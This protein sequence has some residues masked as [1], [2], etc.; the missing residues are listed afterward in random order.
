MADIELKCTCP[1][2]NGSLHWPCPSHP[3]EAASSVAGSPLRALDAFEQY[4]IAQTKIP[5]MPGLAARP[6]YVA[7]FKAGCLAVEAERA[8]QAA[9]AALADDPDDDPVFT[10]WREDSGVDVGDKWVAWSAWCGA[11]LTRTVT[12]SPVPADAP[13]EPEMRAEFHRQH[14]GRDLKQH[15]LRGTYLNGNIAALWNQHKRTVNWMMRRFSAP[16]PDIGIPTSK[17]M[18]AAA[19][20]AV[21]G[22]DSDPLY[23]KAVTVVRVGQRASISMVQRVL[24]IGYNRAAR[25]LEAMEKNG[26]ISHADS[27]GRRTVLPAPA[28]QPAAQAREAA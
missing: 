16:V 11:M 26:V 24:I 12:K 15:G 22:D 17:A 9:P 1:S 5:G 3:P 7:G 25:L 6:C 20:A 8:K 19:P 27:S 14:E 18:Q 2:G 13:G 4:R 23:D 21:Q 28:S 10:K